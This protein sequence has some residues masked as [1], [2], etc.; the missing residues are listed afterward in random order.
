MFDDKPSESVEVT[1]AISFLFVPIHLALVR[2][3]SFEKMTGSL[4]LLMVDLAS[5]S[6]VL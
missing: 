6:P 2:F 4:I 5:V 1:L 3:R